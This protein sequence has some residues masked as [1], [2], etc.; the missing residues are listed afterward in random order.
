MDV[1]RGTWSPNYINVPT[2][3]PILHKGRTAVEWTWWHHRNGNN[4]DCTPKVF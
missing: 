1:A 4:K 3:L 2:V